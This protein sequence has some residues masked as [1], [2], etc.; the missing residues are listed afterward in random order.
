MCESFLKR[1]G[2]TSLHKEVSPRRPSDK[3]GSGPRTP[4]L[5]TLQRPASLPAD[6]G[7]LRRRVG[8][9]EVV[10]EYATVCTP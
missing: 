4:A 2:E 7:V 3:D 10:E 8:T 1:L 9:V 6:C 5:C